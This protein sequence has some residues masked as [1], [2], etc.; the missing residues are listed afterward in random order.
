MPTKVLSTLTLTLNQPWQDYI[1]STLLFSV[2]IH[3]TNH[4]FLTWMFFT[5]LWRTI[6]NSGRAGSGREDRLEKIITK[7]KRNK[8]LKIPSFCAVFN[9]SNCADREKDKPNHRFSSIGREGLKLSKVRRKNWLAQIFR[10]D[11]TER[12]LER[13]RIRNDVFSQKVYIIGLEKQV[14]ILYW[15]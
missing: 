6:K 12:K 7:W 1:D 11:L 10:K 14:R 9:C 5:P 15:R 2:P 8:N 13:T 3:V 4:A